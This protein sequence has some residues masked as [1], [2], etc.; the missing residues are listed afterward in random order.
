MHLTVIS[1]CALAWSFVVNN[2]WQPISYGSTSVMYLP[3]WNSCCDRKALL[4]FPFVS[5]KQS[6]V[7]RFIYFN[8][9]VNFQTVH[10]FF[11]SLV[12]LFVSASLF[13]TLILSFSPYSLSSIYLCSPLLTCHYVPSFRIFF[14]ICV[15][16]PLNN[17]QHDSPLLHPTTDTSPSFSLSFPLPLF[18]SPEIQFPFVLP[19]CMFCKCFYLRQ[20]K[21]LMLHFPIRYSFQQIKLC[22]YNFFTYTVYSKWWIMC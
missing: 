12:S 10:H 1:R 4:M 6:K 7:K 2:G 20:K 11:P 17:D 15:H 19:Q 13:L 18:P 16:L 9:L 3:D 5:Q 21:M 22:V 14:L 8:Y